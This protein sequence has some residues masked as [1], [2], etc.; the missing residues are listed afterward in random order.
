MAK[1]GYRQR[2]RFRRRGRWS[3]NIQ[4]LAL[5]GDAPPSSTFGDF[6]TVAQNPAQ[7]NSTVSQQY[8]VKNVEITGEFESAGGFS[9][10]NV[11]FYIMYVPEGYPLNLDLPFT[12]PEWI[13][14]YK[15]IGQSAQNTQS[16]AGVTFYQP[17]RIKTRL[18]RRLNTGD[19]I[20]F[21]YRGYN[22][23]TSSSY[24]KFNGLVRWWTKAN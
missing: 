22:S 15:Y 9:I 8:T 24:I 20:V 14:A 3:S 12:H 5:T 19:S 23:S 18:S 10:E 17:P 13:M 4:G 7:V 1:R 6:Y 21:I 11:S 2:S 16:A